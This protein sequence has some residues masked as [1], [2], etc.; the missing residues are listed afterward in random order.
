MARAVDYRLPVS[1]GS[2]GWTK[3]ISLQST[4]NA[5]TEDTPNQDEQNSTVE[6]EVT[7]FDLSSDEE[8][9]AGEG[10]GRRKQFKES[11]N[12]SRCRFSHGRNIPIWQFYSRFVF[13]K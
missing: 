10:Y 9:S 13:L 8:S 7:E 4:T 3:K 5:R 6:D 12:Y 11:T 1:K 2:P